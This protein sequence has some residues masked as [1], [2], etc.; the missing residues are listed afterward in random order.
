ML[1]ATDYTTTL[2]LIDPTLGT[3]GD[4]FKANL[5]AVRAENLPTPNDGDIIIL[6]NVAVSGNLYRV[7]CPL[8]EG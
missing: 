8:R 3:S 2:N 7:V 6:T 4:V 5:F 1:N